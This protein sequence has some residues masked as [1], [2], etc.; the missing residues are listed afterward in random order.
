MNNDEVEATSC[1]QKFDKWIWNSKQFTRKEKASNHLKGNKLVNDTF[2]FV[3]RIIMLMLATALHSHQ[4]YLCIVRKKFL[5]LQFLTVIG[6]EMTFIYFVLL[7]I[8]YLIDKCC[9]KEK[10]ETAS[11]S[12]SLF[13]LWKWCSSFGYICLITESHI[14]I[15]YWLVFKNNFSTNTFWENADHIVPIVIL[16]VDWLLNRI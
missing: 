2:L 7:F 12:A 4:I 16:T 15:I 5:Q 10:D 11:D 9:K 8:A 1:W 6:I 13:H 14:T 3:M